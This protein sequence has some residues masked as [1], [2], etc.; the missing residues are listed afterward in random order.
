MSAGKA[1][2]GGCGTG[3]DV[4]P[5][6]LPPRIAYGVIEDQYTERI[7]TAAASIA[8]TWPAPATEPPAV[9]E[10]LAAQYA[11][12]YVRQTMHPDE[13][14]IALAAAWA[15]L[16]GRLVDEVRRVVS[17]QSGCDW[18]RAAAEHGERVEVAEREL[19]RATIAPCVP[20]LNGLTTMH[21]ETLAQV[22]DA[23]LPVEM[24]LEQSARE[25]G[26]A[27][28]VASL[29]IDAGSALESA[30]GIVRRVLREQA[31]VLVATRAGE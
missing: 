28:L 2:V 6:Y 19:R 24:V 23:S 27:M 10:W 30:T 14:R 31:E 16:R 1:L 4:C 5:L 20:G 15:D 26:M 21:V 25:V 12:L 7:R 3:A 8:T 18:A 22:I 11:E 17:R 13:G 9:V 29:G